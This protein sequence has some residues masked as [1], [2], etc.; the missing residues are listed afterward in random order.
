MKKI[1]KWSA[2]ILAILFVIFISLFALD[3]FSDFSWL[4]LFMNLI[5]TFVMIAITVTAWKRPLP[6]GILFVL[7]GAALLVLGRSPVMVLPLVIPAVIIGALFIIG[8][9][10]PERKAAA[11]NEKP[12]AVS[13]PLAKPENAGQ[14]P[15]EKNND[16]LFARV[17]KK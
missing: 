3:V 12:E 6:G 1:I 16:K 13:A 15:I 14:P 10:W 17:D 8:R 2:R 7:A 4:A 11:T 9:F 5:P